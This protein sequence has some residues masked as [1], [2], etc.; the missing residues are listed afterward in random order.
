LHLTHHFHLALG[1]GFREESLE[2]VTVLTFK[3]RVTSLFLV[4]QACTTRFAE[5]QGGGPAPA[6]RHEG[7]HFAFGLGS[8]KNLNDWQIAATKYFN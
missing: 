1:T 7:T 4:L 3:R 2:K 6:A 8:F 5:F